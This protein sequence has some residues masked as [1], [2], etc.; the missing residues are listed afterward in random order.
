MLP[1]REDM[2]L[3]DKKNRG[4]NNGGLSNFT[5]AITGQ[6]QNAIVLHFKNELMTSGKAVKLKNVAIMTVSEEDTYRDY[7][8]CPSKFLI[9][10]LNQIENG[11]NHD[12][13]FVNE[14][15]RRFFALPWGF[16]FW[17]CYSNGKD[18]VDTSQAD[19]AIDQIAW[20]VSTASDTI[21]RKEEELST[22]S[23]FLVYLVPSQQEA[24][25][26]LKV[27][28]PLKACGTYT[29]CLHPG[30]SIDHQIN[31]LKTCEPEFIISTPERLTELISLNAIDLS[32]VS[33][34]VIDGP[35][36][37]V[38]SVEAIKSIKN[39]ISSTSQTMVFGGCLNQ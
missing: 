27:C 4:L 12:G 30:T 39:S 28:N 8:G 32:G 3:I 38:R 33:F 6:E 29:V 5:Q 17:K 10:C 9:S 21:A 1:C 16:E 13:A 7:D 19:S 24:I 23:P 18:I 35:A 34:L 26:V 25:K 14:R 20:I 37:D 2:I 22:T 11:L 15:D 36:Y 31:D